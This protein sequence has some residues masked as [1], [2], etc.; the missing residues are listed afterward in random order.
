MRVDTAHVKRWNNKFGF[1]NRS[2]V[3]HAYDKMGRRGLGRRT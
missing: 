1:H 2:D 3:G